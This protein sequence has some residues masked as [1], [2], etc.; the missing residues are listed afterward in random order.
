MVGFLSKFPR[1]SMKVFLNT[2]K[3][4]SYQLVKLQSP[5]VLGIRTI[6]FGF[7]S[8]SSDQFGFGFSSFQ[9]LFRIQIGLDSDLCQINPEN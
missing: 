9:I 5:A 6:F 1:L 8:C 3:N 7:G 2:S 4:M